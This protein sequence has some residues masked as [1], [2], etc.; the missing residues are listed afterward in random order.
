MKREF[1]SDKIQV[2]KLL[3]SKIIITSIIGFIG[4]CLVLI[5]LKKN[6]NDY[7]FNIFLF[8]CLSII[9]GSIYTFMFSIVSI[10]I[11]KDKL[12]IIRRGKSY[13][14]FDLNK[15]KFGSYTYTHIFM[16]IPITS[17]YLTIIDNLS[18]KKYNYKCQSFSKLT[19]EKILP[20][21]SNPNLNNNNA[22]ENIESIQYTFPKD[23]LLKST[24]KKI[25]RNCILILLVPLIMI[26]LMFLTNKK[27]SAVGFLIL[28]SIT[29]FLPFVAIFFYWIIKYIQIDKKTPSNISID[30]NNIIIDEM[31]FDIKLIKSISL[32]PPRYIN[33]S[34][35]ATRKLIIK[36][37][38]IKYM[39][40]LGYKFKNNEYNKLYNDIK[41][42]FKIEDEIF[43]K[44]L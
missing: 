3:F 14:E 32:T 17:R 27:P 36:Y 39:Y 24:Y 38:N 26:A 20:Y 30:N 1:K 29:I 31:A 6:F 22:K 37:N 12:L 9:I 42:L 25:K 2:I 41:S 10:V 40:L 13:K 16:L 21:L 18:F 28:Y 33:M 8:I 43:T 44:I 23:E 4:Y 35:N 15:Y 19:F 7:D 11:D 5:I 34:I